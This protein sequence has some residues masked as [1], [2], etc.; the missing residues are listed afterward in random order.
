[1]KKLIVKNG[2]FVRSDRGA[3]SG[4]TMLVVGLVGFLAFWSQGSLA[5]VA[6]ELPGGPEYVD[7][8]GNDFAAGFSHGYSETRCKFDFVVEPVEDCPWGQGDDYLPVEERDSFGHGEVA[9]P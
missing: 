3:V 6:G 1:M 5:P 8:P 2:S 9:L 7:Q 4:S